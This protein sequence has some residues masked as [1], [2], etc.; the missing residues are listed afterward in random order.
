MLVRNI[1][2]APDGK[3]F[4]STATGEVKLWR[5][6]EKRSYSSLRSPG[7]GV[8]SISYFPD[9]KSLIGNTQK[10][11]I[12]NVESGKV[13]SA[14]NANW[15]VLHGLRLN[16]TGE[17]LATSSSVGQG[18]TQVHELKLFHVQS[19]KELVT[20]RRGSDKRLFL[21]I[22][23]SPDNSTLA[24]GN[25]DGTIS[26]L[27]IARYTQPSAAGEAAPSGRT[28]TPTQRVQGDNRRFWRFAPQ[29]GGG[30][31]EKQPDGRW[32]EI[33]RDGRLQSYWVVLRS[34]PE[35]IELEGFGGAYRTRL[36][37]GKAWI[38]TKGSDYFGP[39][40]EGNWE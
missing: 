16:P 30:Y 17:Y 18:A 25:H 29:H 31:F 4:A 10:G 9:G 19:G 40:P 11:T 36:G 26:L 37:A 7:A 38:A 34:T 1:A 32:K 8:I 35:Y 21:D 6:G 28:T 3:T 33:G 22:A 13:S 14:I 20:L 5:Q 24:V 2:V 12:W 27:D 23:F 39:S 15:R